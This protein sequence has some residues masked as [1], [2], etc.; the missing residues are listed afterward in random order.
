[1]SGT[2]R[3]AAPAYSEAEKGTLE[4]PRTMEIA[5]PKD[6]KK[7]IFPDEKKDNADVT[8]LPVSELKKDAPAAVNRPKAPAKPKRK[9]SKW[10]LWQLWFNTYRYAALFC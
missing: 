2:P 6:E 10:I 9:V 1:M 3:D 8:T 4:M 7:N 5:Y